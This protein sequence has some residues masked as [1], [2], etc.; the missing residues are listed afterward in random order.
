MH[1]AIEAKEG[2]RIEGETQTFATITIQNYYRLYDKLAGMTGTAETEENEFFQI[3]GM[4][5]VVIPTNE[6]VRREDY[7]DVVYRTRRE[8]YNAV[9][10]EVEHEHAR[11][12]PVLV[13]T[14]S[15][16]V[17]ETLSRLLKR[18]NLPH[19]VLNAKHHQREAEIVARAGQPGAITIATNMAGRGTDIKLGTGLVPTEWPEVAAEELP[20]GWA[21]DQLESR[22]SEEMPWGLHI[23]G[24]ERH[25]SRRIDRQ[26]RGRSGRQGDP[27]SSRFF[28][29]LEDDLMRLFG[30][31]R[32]ATVM[33]KLGAEEGEVITHS[34]VT[35][36]IERAQK[37]VELNNFEVRKR[38]LEYDD[39]MNK[40]R[41]VIY[42]LRARALEGDAEEVLEEARELVEGSVEGKVAQYV[43]AE[44][45]AE[46]WN[47]T[48]LRE[49]LMRSFLLPFDWLARMG[50]TGRDGAEPPDPELP[51]TYE[52]VVSRV[53]EDLA[54]AFER[55]V[56][57][58][59]PDLAERIVRRV[60]LGVID[61]KWREH[62]YELDQL[63]SGI[64]Y[65]AWGQRDPLIEYKKE[66]FEMFVAMMED[67][68]T[69]A[70]SVLYRVQVAEP[71]AM[72]AQDRRRRERLQRQQVALKPAATSGTGIVGRGPLDDEDR[73]GG[74]A[75]ATQAPP[76][77][78][79]F[80]REHDKVGRNDP[81]PCGSGK[82]YK[83]CHGA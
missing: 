25:E 31:E 65:R 7:E 44:S 56:E 57:V 39:V 64:Q 29:S 50:G 68:R 17:S 1:Q 24:T 45:Y 23:V 79:T 4:E 41:E 80:V 51:S 8:K 82:K 48:D 21:L 52:E 71:G 76:Q 14:T 53:R 58:W 69:T 10:E 6:P 13:G 63:K 19:N 60:L 2:V 33:D 75:T 22:L 11:K 5:V 59:E 78:Q 12:R 34:L 55:R 77:P 47:L 83:K 66:A 9:I 61:E 73:G 67:L 62:L 18:R 72:T 28:L 81:C 54:V 42:E 27:G 46:D 36:S 30:S 3:Y 15:V 32:I 35:R 74:T 16:E 40:Q 26:L 20:E 37:K 49:D 38:L 43:D 70:A